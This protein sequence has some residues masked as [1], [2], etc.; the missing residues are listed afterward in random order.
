[1]S[2]KILSPLHFCAGKRYR[3][4]K[5]LIVMGYHGAASHILGGDVN[6]IRFL[7][8]DALP[9]G[10]FAF[11]DVFRL[12]A[13]DSLDDYSGI[14]LRAW[15]N[16]PAEQLSELERRCKPTELDDA[17][18]WVARGLS[19]D[20]AILKT[21]VDAKERARLEKLAIRWR[22]E[23]ARKAERQRIRKLLES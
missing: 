10:K 9:I 7:K 11:D 18:R 13:N 17:I 5:R 19:P 8:L 14:V 1:M 2:E 22:A 3:L 4:A 15:V 12:K 21:K 20:R 6:D 23:R 16:L